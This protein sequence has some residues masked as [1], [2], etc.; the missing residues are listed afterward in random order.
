MTRG[1]AR[2]FLLLLP[3]LLAAPWHA[4]AAALCGMSGR[5]CLNDR[6]CCPTL[7]CGPSSLCVSGCR[8]DGA[9]R[10]SGALDPANACRA[11]RPMTS[12]TA[13]TPVA[14]GATCSDGD[15]CST[16]D[17]CV[18]GACAAGPAKSC[19]DSDPCTADACD[20]VRGCLHPVTACDDGDPCTV[21]ACDPATGG[22]TSTRDDRA[23]DDA[24]PCTADGCGAGAGCVHEPIAGS[25]DDKNACTTADAC[26][27]GV[28]TGGPAL[29]CDDGNPC[30]A[31]ACDPATGCR[32]DAGPLLDAASPGAF[33]VFPDVIAS[34]AAEGARIE[35][36]LTL[37]N[38]ST[39]GVT[40]HL[41][42]L[43]GDDRDPT[44]CYECDFDVPVG[45]RA[46][47]R[48]LMSRLGTTTE[49]RNLSTGA[50]RR[51]A[52]RI[53]FVAVDLEDASHRARTD[54]VLT[55]S[56]TVVNFAAGTT[57]TLPAIAIQGK[58]GDGNRTFAFDGAEYRKLPAW[59]ETEFAAPDP[60]IPSRTELV[61][62]TLGFERQF[63]PLTDCS[64]IG[65]DL[66][67]RAQFSSSIQFG[68]WRKVRLEDIDPEF[69]R[70]DL[71]SDR[72][73]IRLTCTV[74]GG[75]G[76]GVA[77]GGVHGAILETRPGAA[78]ERLLAPSPHAGCPVTLKL[79]E[80]ARW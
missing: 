7:V 39:R 41:S 63:P 74:R 64:V 47:V 11:C 45:A 36:T 57:H 30:T 40:A 22:C 3:L 37:K 75:A 16:P 67:R 68:C 73:G 32:Q 71:G 14:D 10:T 13:W 78:A 28:C 4:P 15:A 72:G 61:L 9:Y 5:S 19:A 77:G 60:A 59:V 51:C 23:C 62:F 25:C 6:Q 54:N 53:G 43:N 31:D 66:P 46:S 2:F 79:A 49:I 50:S 58:A 20:P 8:I 29:D 24:N 1:R 55:G 38:T 42:F 26:S 76:T 34:S 48:L 27:A 21:D 69:L 44:Y 56:S 12:T 52:A 35:T 65:W 17:R 80:P 33:L 18:A 70:P